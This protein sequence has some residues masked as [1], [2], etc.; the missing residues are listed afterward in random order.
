MIS[1]QGE[2]DELAVKR[3]QGDKKRWRGQTLCVF[4]SVY[5]RA[6]GGIQRGDTQAD[7]AGKKLTEAS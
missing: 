7:R 2:T 3:K 5:I 1:Q 6:R 4:V